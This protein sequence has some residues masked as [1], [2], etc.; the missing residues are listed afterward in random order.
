MAQHKRY[1]LDRILVERV[2]ARRA[3]W[4]WR[5][6]SIQGTEYEYLVK[7]GNYDRLNR[8]TFIVQEPPTLRD[9]IIVR[10]LR[11]P[12]KRAWAGIDRKSIVFPPANRRAYRGKVYCKVSLADPE[13]LKTKFIAR[14]QERGDLPKWMSGLLSKMRLKGTVAATRGRDHYH[15]VLVVDR[16]DHSR[17]IAIFFAT[18]VWVLDTGY[19]F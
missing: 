7:D 9:D 1:R 16:D 3:T 12:S 4:D 11:V 14:R 6:R 17:M 13:G 15:Q 2:G 10:P 19:L 18:K 8:W 5:G